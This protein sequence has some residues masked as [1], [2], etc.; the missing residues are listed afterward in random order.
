MVSLSPLQIIFKP[1]YYRFF[2]FFFFRFSVLLLSLLC[3]TTN[4]ALSVFLR[5]IVF[6]SV[7]KE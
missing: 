3:F 4:E 6:Y 7:G 1:N 2:F 5:V